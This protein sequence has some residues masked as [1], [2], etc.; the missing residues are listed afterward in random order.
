MKVT[1]VF[2]DERGESRFADQEIE[3]RDAG[4]IGRLSETI[5]AR[6]VPADGDMPHTGMVQSARGDT[7]G[8]GARGR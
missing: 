2:A 4:P 1:R 7:A 3:L 6:S 8:D 5:P